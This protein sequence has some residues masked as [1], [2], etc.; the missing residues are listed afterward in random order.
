MKIITGDNME[1]KFGE[2]FINIFNR[3]FDGILKKALSNATIYIVTSNED[4]ISLDVVKR[5]VEEGMDE[6]ANS[7]ISDFKDRKE[8]ATCVLG[9]DGTARFVIIKVDIENDEDYYSVPLD[10]LVMRM[11]EALKN[12]KIIESPSADKVQLT[13]RNIVEAISQKMETQVYVRRAPEFYT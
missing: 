12:S 2:A 11:I 5:L 1:R 9:K 13:M 3:E 4:T 10:T 8:M 7:F 6:M